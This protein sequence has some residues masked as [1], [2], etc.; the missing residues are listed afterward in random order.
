MRIPSA[1]F[2]G[3][4]H[5]GPLQPR[6]DGSHA[7][8]PASRTFRRWSRLLASVRST[9]FLSRWPSAPVA[10]ETIRVGGMSG[11][12]PVGGTPR[13]TCLCGAASFVKDAPATAC[14][15]LQ[16]PGIHSGC[17]AAPDSLR[18]RFLNSAHRCR[19]NPCSARLRSA[20]PAWDGLRSSPGRPGPTR[21]RA[22]RTP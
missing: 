8:L 4:V 14:Y 17:R 22:A 7:R 11:C 6:T 16:A 20:S 9:G 3:L 12:G 21:T 13:S 15:D 5:A 19:A 10:K 2:G 18:S 1:L